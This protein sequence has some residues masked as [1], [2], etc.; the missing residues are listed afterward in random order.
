M[1]PL[2]RIAGSLRA[3]LQSWLR[4]VTFRARLEGE[5][6]AELKFHFESYIDDLVER[7][8]PRAQAERQ[9]RIEFGGIAVHKEEMRASLGLRLWDDLRADLAMRCACCGRAPASR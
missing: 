9:A 6:D 4:A 3:R 7:G 8:V 1:K 5:M 2:L